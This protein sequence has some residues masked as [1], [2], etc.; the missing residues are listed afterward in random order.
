MNRNE[1]WV[2]GVGVVDKIDDR[3]ASLVKLPIGN[4]LTIRGPSTRAKGG[5]CHMKEM[6]KEKSLCDPTDIHF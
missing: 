3:D 5:R 2:L 4:L 1:R 6:V